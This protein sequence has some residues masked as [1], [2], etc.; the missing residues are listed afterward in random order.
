MRQSDIL[1]WRHC[2]ESGKL[3]RALKG[4]GDYVYGY[5]LSD[6]D[7][8]YYVGKGRSARVLNHWDAAA[9]GDDR[10]KQFGLIRE[11]LDG[12]GAPVVRILAYRVEKTAQDEIY[13]VIERVLQNTFGVARADEREIGRDRIRQTSSLVQ[14]RDD[15]SMHPTLS[16]EAAYCKGRLR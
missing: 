11:C 6:E 8:P 1:E 13:S 15:G 4:L 3:T 9:D 12:G 16:L 10:Y 14:V 5:Y 2:F 7:Q